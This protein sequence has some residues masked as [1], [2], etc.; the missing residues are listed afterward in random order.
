MIAQVLCQF[1]S[2]CSD[3]LIFSWAVISSNIVFIFFFETLAIRFITRKICCKGF[4]VFKFRCKQVPCSLLFGF[5]NLV[6]GLKSLVY[7][8]KD[9]LQ[10]FSSYANRPS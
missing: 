6:F 1:D 10:G 8:F 2:F 4:Y 9:M 3:F 5:I 7:D